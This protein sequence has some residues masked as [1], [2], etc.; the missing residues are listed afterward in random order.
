MTFIVSLGFS[1]WLKES[2]MK[3][4]VKQTLA[5]LAVDNIVPSN[6]CINLMYK[7]QNKEM[8]F[9]QGLELLREMYSVNNQLKIKITKCSDSLMWYCKHVG[10]T[11][12]VLRDYS[13][14]SNEYLVR[15][16]Y[17]YLNIIRPRDCVIVG[18]Q[19]E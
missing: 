13:K 15:D 4:S 6:F 18:E 19:N 3:D 1:F 5:I 17:G 2:I 11:Y 16:A 14:E 10:E 9:K 7:I 8:T 12:T